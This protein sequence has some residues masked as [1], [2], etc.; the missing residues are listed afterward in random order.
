MTDIR[1]IRYFIAVLEERNITRTAERLGMQQSPLSAQLKKLEQI[2]GPQLVRRI[3]GGIEPTPEGLVLYSD[4]REILEQPQ[5]AEQ[6]AWRL[7]R[8][9]FGQ[10]VPD[11]THSA[12]SHPLVKEPIQKFLEQYRDVTLEIK[13]AGSSEV[14]LGITKNQLNLGFLTPLNWHGAKV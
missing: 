4:Y 10:L 2:V 3:L 12:I 9:L 11:V 13:P 8:G 5:V 1:L 6:N 7:D 14:Y